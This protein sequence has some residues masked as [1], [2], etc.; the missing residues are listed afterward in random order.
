ML[1]LESGDIEATV[2]ELEDHLAGAEVAIVDRLHLD[3]E[4]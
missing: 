2:S 4:G 1:L 3:D